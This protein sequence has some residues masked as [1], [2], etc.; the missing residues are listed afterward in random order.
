MNIACRHFAGFGLACIV[1]ALAGCS[2]SSA[3]TL[4]SSPTE[5]ASAIAS[6]IESIASRSGLRLELVSYGSE[7]EVA[8]ALAAGEL[9][10][11]VLEQP[12]GPVP[13]IGIVSSLYPSVLHVLTRNI[14]ACN[15]GSLFAALSG[16][17]VFAGNAGSAGARLLAELSDIG[18][19]PAADAMRVLPSVFGEAPDTFLIFGGLLSNDARSRLGGYCLL[20]LAEA[21][22]S[23]AAG[24]AFRFPHLEP[25][26]LPDGVYPELATSD[27][28]SLAVRTLL[29]GRLELPDEVVFDLADAI[30][31][32]SAEL[33]EVFPL[34]RA[35]VFAPLDPSRLS[36]PVLPGTQRYMEK[37]NPG[38]LERYAEILALVVTIGI[39]LSSALVALLRVRRQAR[40]D[41]LDEY[42]GRL[43]ALRAGLDNGAEPAEI[44]MQIRALQGT[45]TQL[46]I[47][48]R[49]E[50][51]ASFV[52]F[53]ALSGEVLG[54]A[55]AQHLVR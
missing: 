18:I 9:D 15:S 17:A 36:L 30:A 13:G 24:A 1:L 14:E 12:P 50:A 42:F 39:A 5:P 40:K 45:V 44:A 23:L 33:G 26:V 28:T 48:E 27:V 51:D 55:D 10:L 54:E 32:N 7:E 20:S 11:A 29:L 35:G 8:A 52:A 16:R 37:D 4:G 46:L 22:R 6:R 21:E 43:L 41:R 25:F 2:E 34:A 31:D 53:V 47:D 49:I 38:I 3:L 19:A